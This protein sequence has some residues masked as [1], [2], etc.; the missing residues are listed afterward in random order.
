MTVCVSG[1]SAVEK[2]CVTD[3][4]LVQQF[5]KDAVLDGCASLD[6]GRVNYCAC[7]ANMCNEPAITEQM[8]AVNF[9]PVDDDYVEVDRNAGGIVRLLIIHI[10][11]LPS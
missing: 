3:A 1:K 7:T 2:L 10:G 4:L 6:T 8:G 11:S 9:P 5:G